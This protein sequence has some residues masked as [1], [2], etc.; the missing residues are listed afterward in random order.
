MQK[1]YLIDTKDSESGEDAICFTAGIQGAYFGAGTIHA[2]LASDRN[3]PVVVA[4]ISTGALTGAA[5][6]KAYTELQ[7]VPDDPDEEKERQLRESKRWSWFRMYLEK[8]TKDP[9]SPLWDA[10]PNPVDFFAATFPVEDPSCPETL[11]GDETEA[12][13][14]YLRLIRL[15][16][17]FSGLRVRV[18]DIADVLVRYVRY[19]EHYA[20]P[21]LQGALGLL[22]AIRISWLVAFHA[23]ISPQIS[24]SK[25]TYEGGAKSKTKRFRPVPIFG[26]TLWLSALMWLAAWIFSFYLTVR[27][28]PWWCVL[29]LAVTALPFLC[30]RFLTEP[31]ARIAMKALGIKKGLLHKYHL[32]RWLH[33]IFQET[34]LNQ[35]DDPQPGP[36]HL[37]VVAAPLNY[38][39]KGESRVEQLWARRYASS[40]AAGE[41][42]EIELREALAAALSIRSVFAPEEVDGQNWLNGP[43]P[44]MTG[45]LQLVDGAVIRTNPIPALFAWMKLR[46]KKQCPAIEKLFYSAK[47]R[48]ASL[49]VV[50]SVPISSLSRE[51]EIKRESFNIVENGLINWS[52]LKRRDTEME[53]AQTLFISSLEAETHKGENEVHNRFPLLPVPISPQ[54]ELRFKNHLNPTR[55]EGLTQVAEGCRRTLESIYRHNLEDSGMK[56]L[57]CSVLL[58]EK[59]PE[60]KDFIKLDSPGMPEVCGYCS[61]MLQIR[62]VE[63]S[64]MDK[65]DSSYGIRK[66]E[67]SPLPTPKLHEKFPQLTGVAAGKGRSRIV[68]VANG[69]VF[70]GSFHVGVL[71]ALGMAGVKP[72]LV[73]GSSIG[74]IIGAALAKMS[75]IEQPDQI[76][77]F[78]NELAS[79]FLH[80]DSRVALTSNL[81]NVTRQLGVR[82]RSIQASPN[83]LRSL[84]RSGS[85]KD[86]GYAVMGAP[87]VMIDSIADLF[88]IPHEATQ[89]IA[90]KFVSGDITASVKLFF[91]AV[92]EYTLQRLSVE[93]CVM[94]AELLEDQVRTLLF[95]KNK[96]NP[97]RFKCQ[98][99]PTTA[100]FATATHL[101]RKATVLLGRDFPSE[102]RAPGQFDFV[103]ACLSSSAFP[104]VFAPRIGSDLFPGV[105]RTDT[106]LSDGGVFDNLPFFPAIKVLMDVQ[107]SYAKSSKKAEEAYEYLRQRQEAPAIL[108]AAGLDFDPQK[109][110]SQGPADLIELRRLTESL[111][112]NIKI[113]SFENTSELVYEMTKLYLSNYKNTPD[114][115]NPGFANSVVPALVL[116]ILPA[117]K[118]HLNPTFAFCKATGLK[119]QRMQLS[120]AHG[121]FQT[122]QSLCSNLKATEHLKS[123]LEGLRNEKRAANVARRPLGSGKRG[124]CPFYNVDGKKARCPFYLSEDLMTKGIYK[125]CVQDNLHRAEH[126]KHNLALQT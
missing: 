65:V 6:Y 83:L 66:P 98:P 67:T 124:N 30:F 12:R 42:K 21:Y 25:L 43:S 106:L 53:S 82:G 47:K 110:G 88:L 121:C 37:L 94:G 68:F 118:A 49:R 85:G 122:L 69:G 2:Y 91:Q 29:I 3:A 7:Q 123:A 62:P 74:A 61:R 18:A 87:P 57:H 101:T 59:A 14:Q 33:E 116:K 55:Q 105:G 119:E 86:L 34:K 58:H 38:I 77:A 13:T 117:D 28:G 115:V 52:L 97:E 104:V 100:F 8:L 84:V 81:K 93:E 92:Q 36:F 80:C 17:W 9:L 46:H 20:L 72:D 22:R 120:I 102:S 76:A 41:D 96:D 111:S 45:K 78:V 99:F 11:K 54:K 63:N 4:G 44:S 60:R 56:E 40:E 24:W 125:T 27:F 95:G 48:V 71:A 19:K 5:M 50:Y 114:A 89:R 23:A 39:E 126:R 75:A 90:A 109:T 10:I 51:E 64:D 113:Q 107:E 26:W 31:L 32:Q 73:V 35:R 103:E 79:L 16:N 1:S 108:I 112:N 15:G 70:R